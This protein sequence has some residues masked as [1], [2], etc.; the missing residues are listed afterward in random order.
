MQ[1][2]NEKYMA[3]WDYNTRKIYL[4]DYIE[5]KVEATS[6]LKVCE[7]APSTA[8]SNT[9]QYMGNYEFIVVS[10]NGKDL[11]RYNLKTGKLIATINTGESKEIS[12]MLVRLVSV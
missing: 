1:Y 12:N 3:I 6:P 10:E 11:N 2:I 9:W 7:L 8:Y 5:E 4:L